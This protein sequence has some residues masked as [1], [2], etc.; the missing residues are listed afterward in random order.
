MKIFYEVFNVEPLTNILNI[1]LE[2]YK[3]GGLFCHG[4]TASTA[5][6]LSL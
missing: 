2:N 6:E 1:L 3:S 4:V 5:Q